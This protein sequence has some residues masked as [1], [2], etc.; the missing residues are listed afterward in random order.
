MVSLTFGFCKRSMMCWTLSWSDWESAVLSRL[1]GVT[2]G[3]LDHMRLPS[4]KSCRVHRLG[5]KVAFRPVTKEYR[6]LW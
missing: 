3:V 1:Q 4:P 5:R 2:S 6:Q